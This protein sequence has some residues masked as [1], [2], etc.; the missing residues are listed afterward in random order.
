[1]CFMKKNNSTVQAGII[2]GMLLLLAANAK[3]QLPAPYA[4]WSFQT[5]Q[6]TLDTTTTGNIFGSPNSAFSYVDGAAS[7]TLNLSLGNAPVP[8]N[9]IATPPSLNA[10]SI[11]YS[12]TYNQEGVASSATSIFGFAV[13]N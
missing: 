8:P 9:F 12:Y 13:V 10:Y 3:A 5:V 7:A 2:G 6:G 4:S 1:M 11:A